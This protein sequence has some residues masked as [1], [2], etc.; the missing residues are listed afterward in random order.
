[1]WGDSVGTNIAPGTL[2]IAK[3]AYTTEQAKSWGGKALVFAHKF[4][5]EFGMS[6]ARRGDSQRRSDLDDIF[7]W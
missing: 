5:R 4:D 7:S 3:Y 1:M 2:S 6:C